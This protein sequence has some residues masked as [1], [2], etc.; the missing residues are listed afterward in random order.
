MDAPKQDGLNLPLSGGLVALAIAI[1]FYLTV[2]TPFR[3]ARPENPRFATARV[4][5]A[6]DVQ[7]RLWEDPFVAVE[8]R[9][10]EPTTA[11]GKN[12]LNEDHDIDGL[13]K[14]INKEATDLEATE[15]RTSRPNVVVMP[16]MVFGGPYAEDQETRIRTRHAVLSALGLL[17]YAP[18]DENRI[19]YVQRHELCNVDK[20]V[21]LPKYIPYEWFRST[22]FPESK[23]AV[24]LLWLDDNQFHKEPWKKLAHLIGDLKKYN[25]DTDVRFVI[26]GPAGSTVLRAMAKDADKPWNDEN[27]E[28]LKGVTIYSPKATVDKR[29]LRTENRYLRSI[30]DS[31]LNDKNKDDQGGFYRTIGTDTALART[32]IQEIKRR[33]PPSQR[34][35]CPPHIALISEWDTFYGRTFPKAFEDSLT[36]DE[37]Y[38]DCSANKIKETIIR[39]TYLRGI[40]GQGPGSSLGRKDQ[41][42]GTKGSDHPGQSNIERPVG[43]GQFDYLRR[44]AK[45]LEREKKQLA[46][47]G[48]VGSDVYDKLLVLQALRDRFP[49]AV[50]FTTDLDANLMHPQ[51]LKWTRNL[52]VASHFGLQLKPRWQEGVPP[53]RG[54]YQTAHF[55]ATKL[56]LGAEK[57]HELDK[58]DALLDEPRIFEIGRSGEFDLSL[59]GEIDRHENECAANDNQT[60]NWLI[61]KIYRCAVKGFAAASGEPT[62]REQNSIHPRRK[63]IGATG[64]KAFIPDPS[65]ENS[66]IRVATALSKGFGINAT[67][68]LWL[69]YLSLLILA[70]V[71][72]Y[73]RI[74]PRRLS[75]SLL[76]T[77]FPLLGVLSAAMLYLV[78]VAQGED[79]EPFAWIEGISIW[80]TT[81]LRLFAA[82]LALY[83]W[84]R[85]WLTIRESI[86]KLDK[87]YFKPRPYPADTRHETSQASGRTAYV[88]DGGSLKQWQRYRDR[89]PAALT[90]LPRREDSK[91]VWPQS[92]SLSSVQRLVR[93]GIGKLRRLSPRHLTR[94]SNLLQWVFWAHPD[95]R[96]VPLSSEGAG[97]SKEQRLVSLWI[98][99]HEQNRFWRRLLRVLV[100]ATLFFLLAVSTFVAFG[101]V[102]TPARGDL[103]FFT[104]LLIIRFA[105]LI[106]I[107]LIFWVVDATKRSV[108]LVKA[109]SRGNT[110][111]P[112]AT[113]EYFARRLNIDREYLDPWIDIQFIA[114]HTDVIHRL[115]YFPVVIL[116]VLI[117][118]RAT[119]FD[120]WHF[121]LP[122]II[123][124]GLLFA[125]C[126]YT[127]IILRGA[128]KHARSA[129]VD[130][131]HEGIVKAEGGRQEDEQRRAKQLRLLLDEVQGIRQ[132]AFLPLPQ[133]PWL[134][135]IVLLLGGSGSL[136]YLEYFV[137]SQ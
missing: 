6:E 49:T 128:A 114:E 69:C 42:E 100:L 36:E 89:Q 121:P 50:F 77:G 22:D 68:G 14:E 110:R 23:R 41:A 73:R 59:N 113:R 118:S 62:N 137:W 80:P 16:V 20:A 5:S 55:F 44:L 83:F 78:I 88:T 103:S 51:E 10:D 17:N 70:F 104:H 79:G 109:L 135:A 57:Q 129:V 3:A 54:S 7:A 48:V 61:C 102:Y 66:I 98:N 67:R 84:L 95:Y 120:D 134:R 136:A 24:L 25:H 45:S 101:P 29:Y 111:W 46:A 1:V 9:F 13:A 12:K 4:L 106:L 123:V 105:A 2:E 32:L 85:C 127:T 34:Y 18:R 133:Q 58:I 125:Y 119:Y 130:K 8:R 116:I 94:V 91:W 75:D 72:L 63:D 92:V 31:L 112:A 47:I 37:D 131:L 81:Y 19:G 35:D 87:I 27:K 53:F 64:A 38:K 126:I 90:S 71:L 124:L 86:Q 65:G 56:A 21:C 15:S 115:V 60:C 74:S 82:L 52:I 76:N 93:E 97:N 43:P 99:Y 108:W 39:A 33:I 40:D 107:I 122:L 117:L 132:G 26:Q 11:A 96:Y 28:P 30:F